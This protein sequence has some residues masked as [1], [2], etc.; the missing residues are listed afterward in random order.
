[1]VRP[2]PNARRKH[3][4]SHRVCASE[5]LCRLLASDHLA[6]GSLIHLR[7]CV[8]GSRGTSVG[9]DLDADVDDLL[10]AAHHDH[11]EAIV[12]LHADG[13][14][15]TRWE[16]E[17]HPIVEAD[18]SHF[19]SVHQK[20]AGLALDR[21]INS[22]AVVPDDLHGAQGITVRGRCEV[23]R[24]RPSRNAVPPGW[25]QRCSAGVGGWPE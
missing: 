7:R 18:G 10:P 25:H 4:T 15:L 24:M 5:D 9:D 14:K 12:R 20:H 6:A 16:R 21:G 1:M 3:R 8:P 17:R 22:E 19:T 2:C 11:D 13:M 23:G